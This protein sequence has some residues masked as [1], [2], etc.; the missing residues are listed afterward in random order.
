[1]SNEQF[2]ALMSWVQK[3]GFDP[4]NSDCAAVRMSV[5]T[6]LELSLDE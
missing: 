4:Y 2:K 3:Y 1:M 6:T 5:C